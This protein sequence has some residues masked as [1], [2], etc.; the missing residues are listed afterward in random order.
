MLVA[1]RSSVSSLPATGRQEG[2]SSQYPE[3]G[4][5]DAGLTPLLGTA[6]GC[7]APAV[8]TPLRSPQTGVPG[9]RARG[10]AMTRIFLLR[11][12]LVI[13]AG[14]LP[15]S[16]LAQPSWYLGASAGQSAIRASTGEVDSAFLLDDGFIARGTT[17]DKTHTG[18][19]AYAGYR[20]N[21]FLAVE[22]GYADLGEASFTT[23]IIA[24]PPG[25]MPSPPF[26][27]H[28]TA[29]AHGAFVTPIVHWRFARDFSLFG[30]LGA[31][32]SNAE[33]TE[34]IP[35]T[36]ITRVSRSETRTDLDY[37]AGVE[38]MSPR[39]LGFRLEWERFKNIG[40]GIGG[41]E[42]RD[43]DFLSAGVMVQF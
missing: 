9:Q 27:I 5:R 36:G 33:F 31:F 13:A 41:R 12:C 16:A 38:W 40:R 30:K 34:V 37:G 6:S 3:L 19:K 20:F 21:S 18:W 8:R 24:A 7:L 28:A 26:P 2:G 35:A 42:G 10:A 17:L 14:L 39:M 25:T 15:V 29:T 43:V 32:R 11:K 1:P 22:A 4:T 23:T